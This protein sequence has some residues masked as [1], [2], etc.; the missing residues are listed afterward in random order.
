LSSSSFL[1]IVLVLEIGNKCRK[2]KKMRVLIVTDLEG[3]SGVV[4]WDQ[5]RDMSSSYYQEARR[6]LMG[7]IGAAVDGCLAG[8]A[9]EVVVSD[10]HGGGFNFVPELMHSRARYLTGK[11]RPPMSL[12]GEA[13]KDF[14]AGIFLGFHAMQGT[15]KGLL[16]HTQSSRGGNRYWYN[17][18]ECGEIAQSSLLLGHFGTPVVMVTGDDATGR[19]ARELLGEEIVIAV[20]KDAYAEEFGLL[21]APEAGRALIREGAEKAMG[22]ID[23]CVPL[24]MEL[25]IDGRLCF[26]DKSTADGFQPRRARRID[27][28]TFAATFER[29]FDIYE[30]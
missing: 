27:D 15:E 8:G 16:K 18:R 28:Y 14:D 10:G 1:F 21:L 4:V 6:L 11:N 24:T 17:D 30:F 7:D 13:Y 9:T 22:R 25:P 2:G 5:T 29:A 26:P 23:R 12:R 19:E 3:I 20:V